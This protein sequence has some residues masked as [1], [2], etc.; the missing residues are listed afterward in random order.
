MMEVGGKSAKLASGINELKTNGLWWR[1]RRAEIIA[2]YHNTHIA[3]SMGELFSGESYMDAFDAA[4][5]KYP[6]DV[7]FIIRLFN[8]NATTTHAN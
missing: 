4:K 5:A 8:T 1:E 3:I 7:P 6:G 2:T